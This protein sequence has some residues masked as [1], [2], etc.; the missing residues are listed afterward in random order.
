MRDKDL[1]YIND[2]SGEQLSF[3]ASLPVAGTEH[4]C[5]QGI[6]VSLKAHGSRTKIRLRIQCQPCL[7]G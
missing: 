2:N 7:L 6:V 1:Y 4:A 3:L 5:F